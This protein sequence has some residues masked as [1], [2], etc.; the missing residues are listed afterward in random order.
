MTIEEDR[1]SAVLSS[2]A[3]VPGY[4]LPLRTVRDQLGVVGFPV[5]LDRLRTDAAWLR[6]QGLL[7]LEGEA[8][9]LTDRGRDVVLGLAEVP[10]VKRPEPGEVA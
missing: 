4:C 2:L 3:V 10:G 7:S 9:R 6:E 8:A 5:S 1:R